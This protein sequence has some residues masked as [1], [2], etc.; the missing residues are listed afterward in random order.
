VPSASIRISPPQARTI[1]GVRQP[2]R[3]KALLLRR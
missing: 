3:L 1:V 2:L